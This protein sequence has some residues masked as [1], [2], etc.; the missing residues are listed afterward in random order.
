M[1]VMRPDMDEKDTKKR[2]EV[3]KMLLT[4]TTCTIKDAT[5]MGKKQLAYPIKNLTEGIYVLLHLESADMKVSSIERQLKLGTDV[6]R[7]LLTRA[8]A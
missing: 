5:T 3:V 4:G 8:T 1:V 2:D 6:L 7:Y